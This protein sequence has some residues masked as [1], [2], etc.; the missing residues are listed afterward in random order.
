MLRRIITNAIYF[1]KRIRDNSVRMKA[2]AIVFIAGA[3]QK[4]KKTLEVLAFSAHDSSNDDAAGTFA[5][6]SIVLSLIWIV[7]H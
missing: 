7:G 5:G 4:D 2:P 6:A 1:V 3:V